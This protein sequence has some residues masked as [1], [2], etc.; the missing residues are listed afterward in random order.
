[1]EWRI[2]W[3]FFC[4]LLKLQEWVASKRRTDSFRASRPTQGW[5]SKP[6]APHQP[7]SHH[8]LLSNTRWCYYTDMDEHGSGWQQQEGQETQSCFA[9]TTPHHTQ[10]D[11]VDV[12]V[13]N[14]TKDSC[15]LLPPPVSHC[16]KL[17]NATSSRVWGVSNPR[18]ATKMQTPQRRW[19]VKE[20]GQGARGPTW[21]ILRWAP[22]KTVLRSTRCSW[23]TPRGSLRR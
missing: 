6:A 17:I 13:A 8:L 20:R 2:N 7:C 11:S 1:M 14:K 3:G 10:D 12:G 21:F 5:A 18:G 4:T 9:L 16:S 22:Q 19:T 23:S 15:I